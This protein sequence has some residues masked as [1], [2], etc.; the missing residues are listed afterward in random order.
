MDRVNHVS[1]PER[2]F[3]HLAREEEAR[4]LALD[5]NVGIQDCLAG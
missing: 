1:Q 4:C 5:V 2:L 3:M